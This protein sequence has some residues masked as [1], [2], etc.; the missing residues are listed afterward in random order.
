MSSESV[1]KAQATRRAREEAV[2][3]NRFVKHYGTSWET[4]W[5]DSKYRR[6]GKEPGSGWRQSGW[7]H[8]KCGGT[9]SRREDWRKGEPEEYAVI[10]W[11]M[12]NCEGCLKYKP[13]KEKKCKHC[14][15]H[16]PGKR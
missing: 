3:L 10:H 5:S 15:H 12:V 2:R 13:S 1:I 7:V 14:S 11:G 8:T 4:V 16:C 6:L 9:A